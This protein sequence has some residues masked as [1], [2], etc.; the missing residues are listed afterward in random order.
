MVIKKSVTVTNSLYYNK[1]QRFKSVTENQSWL[2]SY[3]LENI[4]L[5]LP[6]KPSVHHFGAFFT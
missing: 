2:Q 5:I 6:F 4:E 1:N 3:N